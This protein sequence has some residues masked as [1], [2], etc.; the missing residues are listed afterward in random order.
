MEM[1]ISKE[2]TTYSKASFLFNEEKKAVK[3][4]IKGK[5]F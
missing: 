4:S 5:N 3:Q 1:H 2:T